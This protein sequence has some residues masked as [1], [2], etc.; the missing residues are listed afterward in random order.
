MTIG[1]AF[2][3]LFSVACL[4]TAPFAGLTVGD[5]STGSVPTMTISPSSGPTGTPATISG[6]APATPQPPTPTAASELT[7]ELEQTYNAI[8]DI[9]SDKGGH[10]EFIQM[11]LALILNVSPGSIVIEG[12]DPWVTVVGEVGDDGSFIAIGR[13]NVAGFPDISVV[14]EG[15]INMDRIAGEYTMGA[16]GGLPGGESIT[17][18]VIGE[19]ENSATGLASAFFGLFNAAQGAGDSGRMFDMLHPAVLELYGEAACADYLAS[20]ANPAVSIEV[21]NAVEIGEWSW[22]RDGRTL[23]IAD[24]LAVSAN[25]HNGDDVSQVELHLAVRPDGTLGWFTDCG[26]PQ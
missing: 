2:L 18:L 26:E 15:T 23:L 13:G 22:E 16:E 11:L 3:T 7:G 21:L 1:L 24:A 5:V 20:I 14:F 17:Y 25:I 4:C 6:N 8:T 10:A 12:P 9:L 19:A